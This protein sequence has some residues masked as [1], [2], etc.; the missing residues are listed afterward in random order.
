MTESPQVSAEYQLRHPLRTFGRWWTYFALFPFFALLPDS[1]VTRI[2]WWLIAVPSFF[3]S[4]ARPLELWMHRPRPV[5]LFFIL[6]MGVPVV[7][8]MLVA[9]MLRML[10]LVGQ[11]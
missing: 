5:W 9:A 2:G 7:L 4:A 10:G 8:A 1:M 6:W 11:T 3:W